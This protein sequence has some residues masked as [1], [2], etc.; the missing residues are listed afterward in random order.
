MTGLDW[1]VRY[2]SLAA[3][4]T[5]GTVLTWFLASAFVIYVA[6]ATAFAFAALALAHAYRLREHPR[7]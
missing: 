1:S 7:V 3:L 4:S 6:L 2:L 5:A